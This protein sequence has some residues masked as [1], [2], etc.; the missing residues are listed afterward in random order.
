MTNAA[1]E[2]VLRGKVG[3]SRGRWNTRYRAVQRLDLSALRTPGRYQLVC[4]VADHEERGM[5]ATLTVSGRRPS[6]AT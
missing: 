1:G 3:K 5:K 4:T 2:T 6:N